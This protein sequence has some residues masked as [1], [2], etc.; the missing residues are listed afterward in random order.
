MTADILLALDAG[1]TSTRA[2]AFS[3]A[4]EI[5]ASA[6]RPISQ[7]YPA[8]AEVEHDAAEIWRL[9][10]DCLLEVA[11]SV[12]VANIAAIGIT[13]QRETIVFW[14]R[15]SGAPLGR[16]IVWQDRRTADACARL[17]A[18]GHEAQVQATTGLLLDPYFSASK[19]AWALEHSLDVRQ[20]HAAGRLCVG[21][22][23]SWLIWNL[24]AGRRHI[25]DATNASRTALMNLKTCRWDELMCALFGVPAE[26]LPE[27]TDCAGVL[28][29]TQLLGQEIAITASIGDQQ[30]AAVGQG[31]FSPGALKATYGTGCFLLAHA[32]AEVP[33]S[34]HRLLA[35]LAYRLAGQPA[36]ALEGAIFVAG[37][38]VQWLRDGLGLIA[39]AEDSEALARSVAD[40][41]GVVF[42]PAL[43]GLGAP[44]WAPGA[45]GLITGLTSGT[46][47]AHLVRATLEAM[48]QQTA[49]LVDA[50]GA[51]GVAVRALN[52]DGGMVANDWL[53]QDLADSLGVPVQ[54]PAVIETTALGAAALAAVGAGLYP[55]LQAAGE[56]MLHAGGGFSPKLSDADRLARRTAW[57]GAIA[58]TL[59]A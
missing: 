33:Q 54:R 20:A 53:C 15:T 8:P 27:I 41:G 16:A 48:G 42:V 44:H 25:T 6:A 38:A 28:A 31:C 23:D 21:T 10:R 11:D 36:Y 58:R 30:A 9:S 52:V 46:T 2:I 29:T 50:L 3:R 32:G 26:C 45:R 1:T 55:S 13:N 49:D 43:A 14:D 22:V 37:A 39:T 57:Q 34:Q 51:D 5:V 18:A 56:A 12:G 59:G 35:T 40:C 24:S 17:K 4:G 47:R 7:H 19:I